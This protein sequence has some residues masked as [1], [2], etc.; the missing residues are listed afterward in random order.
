[1][2]CVPCLPSCNKCFP[3]VSRM[4]RPMLGTGDALGK[5]RQDPSLPHWPLA[6][7]G[8]TLWLVL[9]KCHFTSS[10][11]PCASPEVTESAIHILRLSLLPPSAQDSLSL[12]HSQVPRDGCSIFQTCF[13][14][15]N[16]CRGQHRRNRKPARQPL[17][18]LRPPH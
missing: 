18:P 1:M 7:R 15:F 17:H 11:F 10:S 9:S 3:S 13:V 6:F 8:L 12:L 4:S 5:D 2:G 16:H 14:F